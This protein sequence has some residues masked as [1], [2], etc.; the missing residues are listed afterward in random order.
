MASTTCG[1][2]GHK[3]HMTRVSDVP[4]I[5]YANDDPWRVILDH[6]FACD[7]CSRY[8]VVTWVCDSDPR[9]RN[10]RAEPEADDPARWNPPA[11][12][13]RDYEGVPGHIASAAREAW[14]CHGHGANIGACAVARAVVEAS[15]KHFNITTGTIQSKIDALAAKNLIWGNLVDAAHTLRQFGN[16]AAH[17]D[18]GTPIPDDECR[19]VLTIMDELLHQLFTSLARTIRL[20]AGRT[21]RRSGTRAGE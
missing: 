7:N 12:E 8:S 14:L 16:D 4:Q 17:G 1:W 13:R 3:S 21:D 6:A 10:G 9:D 2:C 19:D 11:L 20:N 5:G 15:A 18:I